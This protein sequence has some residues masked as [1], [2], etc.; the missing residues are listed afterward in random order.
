MFRPTFYKVRMSYTKQEI[1]E[2]ESDA[3]FWRDWGSVLG[4]TLYGF[5]SRDSAAF[6]DSASGA[7]ITVRQTGYGGETNFQFFDRLRNQLLGV[8]RIVVA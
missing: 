7:Y 3:T 1:T 8:K 6:T 4:L 5:T 2:I